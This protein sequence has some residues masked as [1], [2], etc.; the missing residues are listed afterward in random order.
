M[1][2]REELSSAR[3]ACSVGPQVVGIGVRELAL[4]GMDEVVPLL[5][6]ERGNSASAAASGSRKSSSTMCGYGLDWYRARSVSISAPQAGPCRAR[7]AIVGLGKGLLELEL[8]GCSHPRCVCWAPDDPRVYRTTPLDSTSN[9]LLLTFVASD[10]LKSKW[11]T[12]TSAPATG[13]GGRRLD[14]ELVAEHGGPQARQQAISKRRVRAWPSTP[15]ASRGRPT[16]S[17]RR[18]A[19]PRARPA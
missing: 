4:V 9:S 13:P 8:P 3:I 15:S 1:T 2:K 14:D 11:R 6:V 18:I 7:A 17:I 16:G 19:N 5:V 12:V 10:S